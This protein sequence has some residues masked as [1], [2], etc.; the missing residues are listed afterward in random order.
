MSGVIDADTHIIESTAMW[1]FIDRDMHHRRP[2]ITT[3]P[4]DTL[5]KSTNAFWLIDGNIFPKPAGKGSFSIATPSAQERQMARR[6]IDVGC[7]EI[8][9]PVARLRDMDRLGVDVQVVYPTLF[10]VYVTHDVN[11]EIALCRAYNRWMAQVWAQG[12]GRLRWTAVLPLRSMDESVKE[13]R[14]ARE[15]GA[16]GVFFRGIEGDRSLAEPYFFPVYEEASH[17]NMPICIHT[18]AGSPT[19]ASVFDITISSTL[20]PIR[21]LPLMAFRD[22]VANKIP[23]RFPELRFGFIEAASS[24]VPYI[25]HALKRSTKEDPSKWGPSLFRDYRLFV[26]C[27]ADEDIPYLPNYVDE[28]YLI[29]GSD[30]GHT[31]PST[32]A[33][34]VATMRAR[35]DIPSRVTEKILS[36]NARSFYAI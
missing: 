6:D 11:L 7:R 21:M 15:H 5:Y 19:I 31:D 8:T 34:L 27:E 23:E 35:E 2:V 26:A 17:L 30:Y 13:L 28:D 14:W 10:L 32:E 1:E 36:E 4:N 18:G 25:L 3:V 33:Q 29:I 12:H 24:W 9:D 20:A 22:I 16:V